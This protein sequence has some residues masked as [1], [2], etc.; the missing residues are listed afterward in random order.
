[1]SIIRTLAMAAMAAV[2]SGSATLPPQAGLVAHEWGTFTSIADREGNPMPWRA[3]SGPVP[4][5]CFVHQSQLVPKFEAAATTVRMETPVVYFYSPTATTLSMRV[6]Y[7]RGRMTEWYPAAKDTLN[8]LD[9]KAVEVLPGEDLT[10]P[11]GEMDNHYYSARRTDAA[12]LRVGKEQEKLLFYRGVGDLKIPV[13]PRFVESRIEIRPAGQSPVAGV[14]LFENRAGK[15][16][17]R[18]IGE[19]KEPVRVDSPE[20]TGDIA[21]L[22]RELAD[23]LVTA[24]LYPKEA[25][26]TLDTWRDSW[27]EEGMRVMYIV[28]RAIVDAELPLTITPPPAETAR[29]FVGR[30][31][32]LSPAIEQ[33]ISNGGRQYG[34]FLEA[35]VAMMRPH[36]AAVAAAFRGDF[37]VGAAPCTR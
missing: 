31:E 11:R 4:L 3:T 26:A 14:V 18:V 24:G 9:W 13:R 10:L 19:L 30:I 7:P 28:P 17:Y 27:F 29:V 33:D 35:F 16:G 36:N 1:M 23:A 25:Q 6:Q 15:A 2:V 32:M 5:P 8:M 21:A 12:P 37:T 20:L 22:R 34:R